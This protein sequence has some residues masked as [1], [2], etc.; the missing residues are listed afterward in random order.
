METVIIGQQAVIDQVLAAVLA[1]GHALLEGVPGI[2]K[3]LTISTLA[4]C[5]DCTFARLQFTPDLLPAD[6]TGTRIYDRQTAAFRTIQ[7]PIFHQ[8]ILADE[9]NRAPPKVQSALL[10]AMQERQVTIQGETYPLPRPFFVLATQNPLESE[11]TYPLPEAQLDRFMLKIRMDYP[12]LDEEVAILDRFT[13]DRPAPP[14]PVLDAAGVAEL[15]SF[16]RSVYADPG[17]KRYAAQLV[18]ATRHPAAYGL[19]LGPMIASGASPRASLALLL[20]GK[21]HA[22]LAGR[23]YV[24]PDDI[25][26][27]APA[28]LRHR[29]LLTFE[30][31]A[32]DLTSEEIV[33]E[34]LAAV[35]VP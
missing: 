6:I 25:R 34:I 11:G 19:D 8:I 26:A 28:V 23:G 32:D 9:I 33:R 31:E 1:G 27:L 15:Q 4:H 16:V 21:A 13:A 7:G 17:V 20:C 30:A 2:A 24:V 22:V 18:D 29:V 35:E 3:T 5:L 12:S 14:A 10:E